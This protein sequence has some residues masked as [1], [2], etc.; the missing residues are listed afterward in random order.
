MT[1]SYKDMI[2]INWS[3]QYNKFVSTLHSWSLR[4]L[5]TL[6]ERAEVLNIFGLSRVWYRASILPM[7]SK[8]LAKF[9]TEMRKFIWRNHPLKNLIPLD[10][11]C[12]PKGKGGLNVH[13]ISS[14]CNSLLTRQAIRMIG[15]DS[16]SK[17]HIGFWIG[18]KLKAILVLQIYM[19]TEYVIKG[20]GLGH[21][22]LN[23][24][25]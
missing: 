1:P 9:Q 2:E 14:K 22:N 24:F 6:S 25:Q 7:P 17:G 18:D 15:S 19:Y 4:N 8:W 10:T 3:T 13:H 11:L 23:I 5:S 16:N 12:L 20:G 21:I